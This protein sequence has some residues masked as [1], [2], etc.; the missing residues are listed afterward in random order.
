MTGP[1]KTFLIAEIDIHD[2]AGFAAYRDAV[3]PLIA[4]CG[5]RYLVRGGAVAALEGD[6]PTARIVVIEFPDSETARRF[7]SSDDYAP[8]AAIRHRSSHSRIYMV[9]GYP[10]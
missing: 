8:V 4:A 10:A 9:E 5:G 3:A 6:A 2:P 7:W 1:A